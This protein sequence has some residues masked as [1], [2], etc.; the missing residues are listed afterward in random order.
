MNECVVVSRLSKTA[1]EAPHP[2]NPEE[3][4]RQI[5][6]SDVELITLRNRRNGALGCKRSRP[7]RIIQAAIK[8]RMGNQKHAGATI[9]GS[10]SVAF[11]DASN[12]DSL[13]RQFTPV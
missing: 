3:Q 11:H 8:I 4:C 9:V 5:H 7:W 1:W 12:Q 2:S 6:L 13:L 10:V